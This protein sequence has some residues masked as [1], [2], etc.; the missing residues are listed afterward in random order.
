MADF[1]LTYFA[2]RGRG[3]HVRMM[4]TLAGQKFDEVKVGQTD[5]PALKQRKLLWENE[6]RRYYM[7]VGVIISPFAIIVCINISKIQ[8]SATHCVVS[9][10]PLWIW[11]STTDVLFVDF[12]R[13][14]FGVPADPDHERRWLS[15]YTRY[16]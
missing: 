6:L 14:T 16:M 13:D 3:E 7:W 11:N 2:I 15:Q 1:K 8:N 9:H 12:S 4:L 10:K 5:W